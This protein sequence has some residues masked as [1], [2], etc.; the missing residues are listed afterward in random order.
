MS[1][2]KDIGKECL[3]DTVDFLYTSAGGFG[4]G[5]KDLTKGTLTYAGAIA[6]GTLHMI[7]GM[8]IPSEPREKLYQLEDKLFEK[9]GLYDDEK[10]EMMDDLRNGSAGFLEFMPGGVFIVPLFDLLARMY[11]IEEYDE[12][13]KAY[14]DC[15]SDKYL[16]AMMPIELAY[17]AVAAPIKHFKKIFD[18]YS[19]DSGKQ[20]DD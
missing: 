12:M 14:Q 16:P 9:T 6:Y 13:P 15:T 4:H 8:L 1:R 2:F 18:R 10:K 11:T 17:V 20:L 5:L 3:E 7:P 19:S